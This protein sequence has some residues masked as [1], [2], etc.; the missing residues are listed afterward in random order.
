MNTEENIS[1]YF[2]EHCIFIPVKFFLRVRV[3]AFEVLDHELL[4]FL[5]EI[6]NLWKFLSFD[7]NS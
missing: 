1:A 6:C 7:E 2:L 4:I 5:P 3:R